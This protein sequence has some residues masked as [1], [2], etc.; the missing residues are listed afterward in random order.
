M[1]TLIFRSFTGTEKPYKSWSSPGSDQDPSCSRWRAA[2]GS[3]F[4]QLLSPPW[5]VFHGRI[6]RG[7][8]G[9]SG[10]GRKEEGGSHQ[11]D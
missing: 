3:R 4:V 6:P 1:G 5:V 7:R 9:A 2:S 10:D 8:V 11:G